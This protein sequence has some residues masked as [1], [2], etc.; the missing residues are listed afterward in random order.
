MAS[1]ARVVNTTT[2]NYFKEEEVNILRKRILTDLLR[3]RGRFKFNDGGEKM[4]W[5]VRYRRAPMAGYADLDTI[6][7]P[8]INRWKKAETD[9]RGYNLPDSMTKMERL[10]NKGPSQ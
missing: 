9:W 8:R 10:Q 5:P 1:W 4:N 6:T 3:E 2:K 7:F